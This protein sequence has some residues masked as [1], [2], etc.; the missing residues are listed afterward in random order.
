MDGLTHYFESLKK[1]LFA[2]EL[3]VEEISL[4]LSEVLRIQITKDKIK[5]DSSKSQLEIMVPAQVKNEILIKKEKI[6]L[7]LK[8]RGINMS[9]IK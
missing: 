6:L 5:L 9:E 1:K 4:I 3:K 2:S 7:K 8:E